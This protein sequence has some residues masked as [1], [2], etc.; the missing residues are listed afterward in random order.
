MKDNPVDPIISEV[1]AVR[2]AHAARFDYDVAA[3]IRDIREMQE[4]SGLN[5]VCRPGRPVVVSNPGN[6][7]SGDGVDEVD[8]PAVDSE[9]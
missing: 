1:R 9:K 4:E 7:A 6:D 5:Y 3:I 8:A 2:D